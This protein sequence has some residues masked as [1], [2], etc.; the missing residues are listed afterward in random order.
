MA[1]QTEG[2]T[3]SPG[4]GRSEGERQCGAIKGEQCGDG[5]SHVET[6]I[7]F[8]AEA[9]T[10]GRA[11]PGARPEKGELPCWAQA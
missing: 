11:G 4:E 10:S 5:G 6:E 9:G 1:A 3:V 2:K 8:W 7:L